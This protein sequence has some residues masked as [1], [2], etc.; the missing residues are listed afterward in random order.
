MESR[1]CCTS[2]M[3]ATRHV[4]ALYQI[5]AMHSA[6]IYSS[7]AQKRGR[8]KDLEYPL[9]YGKLG[10]SWEG[11]ALLSSSLCRSGRAAEQH[12]IGLRIW[13]SRGARCWLC[14]VE[15]TWISSWTSSL[16]WAVQPLLGLSAQCFSWRLN[17]RTEKGSKKSIK[18]EGGMLGHC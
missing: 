12:W 1:L 6:S 10:L 4:R 18:W 11:C 13:V 14:C 5:P 2:C 3:C 17:L 15:Q 16:L 7:T 9:G 8:K